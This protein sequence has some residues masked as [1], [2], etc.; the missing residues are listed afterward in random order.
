MASGSQTDSCWFAVRTQLPVLLDLTGL[1]GQELVEHRA[2][3]WAPE[4]I[5]KL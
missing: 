5:R 4:A 2:P 3:S 1:L